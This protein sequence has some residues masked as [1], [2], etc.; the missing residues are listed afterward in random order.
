[1]VG[2]KIQEVRSTFIHFSSE[3]FGDRDVAVCGDCCGGTS[4]F[5]N[6]RWHLHLHGRGGADMLPDQCSQR[7]N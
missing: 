2:V 7:G 1:M 4:V 6:L 5:R 3:E